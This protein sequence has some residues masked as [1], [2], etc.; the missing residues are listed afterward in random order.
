GFMLRLFA[1][2]WAVGIAPS[3]WL[4][5]TGMFVALFLGFSKRRAESFRDHGSKRTVLTSYPDALLD[6]LMA[7]T[8]AALL[9]TY[10]LFAS[11][12]E[13]QLQHGERL[14]YTIPIVIFATLRYAYQ[15][16]QGRGEDVAHDL[17]HDPWAI[18]AALAWA[19]IFLSPHWL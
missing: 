13:A 17:L 6:M 1:G 18:G 11:S 10:S 7:V 8:L 2:T 14:L 19:A 15:V 12:P 3:R 9:M 5:L 4:L 16:H